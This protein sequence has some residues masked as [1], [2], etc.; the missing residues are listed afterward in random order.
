MSLVRMLFI[1]AS[2][3]AL[4]WEDWC[5]VYQL[6]FAGYVLVL[7]VAGIFTNQEID[8]FKAFDSQMHRIRRQ[9]SYW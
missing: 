6:V 2:D 9:S 4:L 1:S 5:L 7:M 3:Y 8:R